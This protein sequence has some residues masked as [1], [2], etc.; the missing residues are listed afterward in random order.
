MADSPYNDC[1]SHNYYNYG[2]NNKILDG[3]RAFLL[4]MLIRVGAG[5]GVLP[6]IRLVPVWWRTTLRC[7]ERTELGGKGFWACSPMTTPVPLLRAKYVPAPGWGPPGGD[8]LGV[9]EKGP[10]RGLLPV[11]EK[12]PV[13]SSAQRPSVPTQAFLLF[14]AQLAFQTI[15][16]AAQHFM[17]CKACLD[18]GSRLLPTITET[19]LII[20]P[21]LH[22]S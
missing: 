4:G 16:D 17:N 11:S 7:V 12:H 6:E 21:T 10:E 18:S 5:E 20:I 15:R 13:V 9:M 8:L 19:S 1:H 3:L 2:G 14:G 22:V